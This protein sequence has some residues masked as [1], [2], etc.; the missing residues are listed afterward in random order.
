MLKRLVN[1]GQVSKLSA[2]ARVLPHGKELVLPPQRLYT[3]EAHI[4]LA[5]ELLAEDI[6]EV[7]EFDEPNEFGE[8][9][10]FGEPIE[11]EVFEWKEPPRKF[12]GFGAI[13]KNTTP[14]WNKSKSFG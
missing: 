8:T 2:Q 3:N 5:D 13:K 12:R 4:K 7:N 10:E 9:N 6:E 14:S 1:L 11:E